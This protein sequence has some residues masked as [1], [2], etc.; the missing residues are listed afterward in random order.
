MNVVINLLPEVVQNRVKDQKQRRL[1]TTVMTFTV[2]GSV[3]LVLFLFVFS[4]AQAFTIGQLSKDI[5]KKQAEIES[6]PNLQTMLTV[7]QHLSSLGTL[8]G[9]RVHWTRFFEI[10]GQTLPGDVTLDSVDITGSSLKFSGKARNMAV[11]AKLVKA[12]EESNVSIAKSGTGNTQPYFTNV[13]LDSVGYGGDGRTAVFA[14][15]ANMQ[16]TTNAQ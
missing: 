4:Q 6:T 13:N 9:Q 5:K 1:A 2:I 16:G 15:S 10:V 3:G 7:Q 11:V 8:Y 12:M 14:I